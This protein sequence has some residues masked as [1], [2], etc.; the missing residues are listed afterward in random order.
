MIQNGVLTVRATGIFGHAL[1]AAVIPAGLWLAAISG[2]GLLLIGLAGLVVGWAYSAPPMKLQARGLGEFA[3]TA[4]WLLVVVG[5][6]YVQRRGWA[7]APVAAGLGFSLLVANVLYIN[8]FPDVRA[9]A[10]AG[11]MTLVVRLGVARARWGYIAL[12]ALAYAWLAL[13]LWLGHLPLPASLALLSAPTSII[14]ARR[15][16]SCSAQPV[17]LPPA[18]KMTILAASSHGLLLTVALGLA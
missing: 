3:I 13:M 17:E 8:Q 4:G 11:K 1:L 18:L 5:S 15:L 12:A 6:D 16:W 9:D 2:S 7:F 10:G 14:A